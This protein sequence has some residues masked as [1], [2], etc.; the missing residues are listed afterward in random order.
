ML[1]FWAQGIRSIEKLALPSKYEEMEEIDQEINHGEFLFDSDD[2]DDVD[3]KSSKNNTIHEIYDDHDV[4]SPSS[5]I[6]GNS[7][8]AEHH[9][10]RDYMNLN[11]V[12][13][14]ATTGQNY[15]HTTTGQS[16]SHTTT[17]QN[18]S[19]AITN[20]TNVMSKTNETNETNVSEKKLDKQL[21]TMRFNLN[22][23]IPSYKY[24][25][26][27]LGL[28]DFVECIDYN[29][30]NL[31]K[32]IYFYRPNIPITLFEKQSYCYH[33]GVNAKSKIAG[34]ILLLL[35]EMVIDRNLNLLIDIF[36]DVEHTGFNIL[37]IIDYLQDYNDNFIVVYD[38]TD[39]VDRTFGD[40]H[41][42][43]NLRY[44]NTWDVAKIR[45]QVERA[46]QTEQ[47][48]QMEVNTEKFGHLNI[49]G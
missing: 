5:H 15:S 37:K 30:K 34:K 12:E 47:I 22:D 11:P 3:Y 36:R 46:L 43:F 38:L 48:L 23:K 27:I 1:N 45:D 32:K 49:G 41:Y 14:N 18:Y 6:P 40:H 9:E 2:D 21:L 10:I 25:K 8:M 24:E 17:A 29:M 44:T 35:Q 7:R 20:M 13:N 16:Y 28:C 19:N 42:Q 26:I 4:E 31:P 33:I 39:S